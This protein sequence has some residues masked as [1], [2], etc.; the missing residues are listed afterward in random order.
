MLTMKNAKAKNVKS[1]PA[2]SGVPDWSGMTLEIIRPSEKTFAVVA[3][4][5]L[6]SA[7]LMPS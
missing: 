2:N 7:R 5:V 6:I 4:C 1:A 3:V